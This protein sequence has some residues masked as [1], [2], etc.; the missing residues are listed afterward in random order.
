M[1][2]FAERTGHSLADAADILA[3]ART[4]AVLG[5]NTRPWKAACYVP[6]FLYEH[7]YRVL[8]VN[9]GKVGRTLWGQAVTATLA[10]LAEP[11][12]IVDVFRRAELIDAHIDDI[13]AMR[14]RPPVVWFQLGI[15]NDAAAGRLRAEGIE[16]VQDRCT[17]ADHRRAGVVFAE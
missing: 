5:A 6:E 9:P 15:R 2:A 13:L 7:G 11:V 16:V 3:R 4:V 12:D 17:L 1:K 10:E 8:P 14:P